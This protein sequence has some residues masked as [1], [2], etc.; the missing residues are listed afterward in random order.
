VTNGE[1]LGTQRPVIWSVVAAAVLVTAAL[2]GIRAASQDDRPPDEGSARAVPEATSTSVSLAPGPAPALPEPGESPVAT[3]MANYDDLYAQIVSTREVLYD[4]SNALHRQVAQLLTPDSPLLPTHIYGGDAGL[5]D[6][7]QFRSV[8]VAGGQGVDPAEL[9]PG[10]RLAT[11][12]IFH[13]VVESPSEAAD[14]AVV[15]V[16]VHLDWI[17]R[18]EGERPPW[19]QGVTDAEV[20]GEIVVRRIDGRWRLHDWRLTGSLFGTAPDGQCTGRCG[21]DPTGTAVRS[22]RYQPTGVDAD[23]DGIEDWTQGTTPTDPPC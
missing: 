11:V 12:P 14:S 20:D 3:L 10:E 15:P 18:P 4:P 8:Q 17:I 7:E 6:P 1:D 21:P 22:T 13:E 9:E 2:T 23:G 19:I 5:G 16:C